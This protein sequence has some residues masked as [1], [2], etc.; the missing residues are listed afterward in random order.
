MDRR[1]FLK[2]SLI[3]AGALTLSGAGAPPAFAARKKNVPSAIQPQGWVSEPSRKIPVVASVDLVV[4]GGGPAG[5]SAAISAARNGISVLLLERYAF[6]GGLWTGGLVLP[7]LSTHGLDQAGE[8]TKCIYGFAHELCSRLFDMGM[9]L[10]PKDPTADPEAAKYVMEQMIQEAGVQ[11]IY[12]STA[13]DVLMSGNRITAVVLETQAGRLAVNTKAVV[14]ASGDGDV[15]AWSGEDFYQIRY[16]I[17]AMWRVGGIAENM[18]GGTRTPIP[19]VRVMHSGGVP[20][21]D[22]LDVFNNTKVWMQLRQEM[23]ERTGKLRSREGGE[24]AFLL[25]TPPQMGVRITRVLKPVRSVTLE[26]SMH[27]TSYPDSIG[28]SGGSNTIK[29]KGQSIKKKERPVWQIPYGAIVPK[30]VKNLLVAGRCFGFDEGLVWD[31]R[32]IGTCFV[33]GQAAGNAAALAVLNR[34][35]VQDVDVASLQKLLKD[36]NAKLSL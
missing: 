14:D 7:V 27:Y 32:E 33:T 19:G 2:A 35:S 11:V 26:E 21:L 36:Q 6:L 34:C 1:N 18:K 3:G 30:K 23:W 17:G 8:W 31:A 5:V 10:N 28:M 9:A 15:M 24:N 29:Y 25:E 16:P 22:G 12:N 13:A 4:V 20:D